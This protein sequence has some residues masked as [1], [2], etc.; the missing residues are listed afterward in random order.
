MYS[1]VVQHTVILN[2]V[3]AVV[4]SLESYILLQY[5]T[6]KNLNSAMI[7]SAIKIDVRYCSS[8]VNPILY[9]VYMMKTKTVLRK[10]KKYFGG[11]A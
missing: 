10:K 1:Y 8:Q 4:H 5:I 2:N 3:S 9:N 6:A 7:K 11:F